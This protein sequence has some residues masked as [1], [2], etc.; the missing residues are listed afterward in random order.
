MLLLHGF[1][2]SPPEV[3]PVADYLNRRGLTV[4]APL[5]P[6]HGTSVSDLNT[7]RWQEW[8]RAADAALSA[9]QARCEIVFVGGLSMGAL[10]ALYLA[11][12]H[13]E[14]QGAIV[15][16]P[17]IRASQWHIYLTPLI[18]YFVKTRPKGQGSDLDELRA[19]DRLWSYESEPVA[20]AAEL[21]ALQRDSRRRLPSVC[22]PVL[23]IYSLRDRTIHPDS[24]PCILR[25][26]GSSDKEDLVLTRSGHCLTVDSECETVAAR[27][28]E[29]ISR[30]A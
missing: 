14:L 26:V 8:A 4:A 25:N 11:A 23:V 13:P 29:F 15:Y 5:L 28:Y 16:S 21:L 1:T 24:G 19:V 7:R 20:A 10:L 17:A 12:E 9:L 6:G 30:R 3:R 2:G 22:C 18:K 27:T